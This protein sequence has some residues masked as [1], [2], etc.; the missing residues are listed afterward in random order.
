MGVCS[1]QQTTIFLPH[2]EYHA[3]IAVGVR[4]VQGCLRSP[5][6]SAWLQHVHYLRCCDKGYICKKKLYHFNLRDLYFTRINQIMDMINIGFVIKSFRNY[7]FATLV[8]F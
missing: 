2:D 3:L 5:S 6:D 1:L 4:R 7:F 8:S